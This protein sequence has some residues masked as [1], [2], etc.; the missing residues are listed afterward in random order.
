MKFRNFKIKFLILSSVFCLLSSLF[1]VAPAIQADETS[2]NSYNQSNLNQ[3]VPRNLNTWTQSIMIE[4]MSSL[5]CQ[6]TGVNPANPSQSC[7]GVDQKTGKIGFMENGGGAIGVMGH[8]IGMLYN[9]PVHTGDFT[10][11]LAQN[12]GIT[13]TAYAQSATGFNTLSPLIG[14][15]SAFRNIVYIVL[16]IIFVLIGLAIMFRVKIDPRTVMTIQNQI[17]KIIIAMVLVT[18]SYA[19]AGLM[20]DFMYLLMYFLFNIFAT[21]PATGTTTIDVTSLNPANLQGKSPFSIIGDIPS[22]AGNVSGSVKDV[23]NSLLGGGLLSFIGWLGGSTAYFIILIAIIWSLFRLWFTLISAFIYILIAIVLSPFWIAGSLIPG[24]KISFGAWIRHIVSYLAVFPLTIGLFLLGKSF[25]DAFGTTQGAGVFVPPLIGNA[26]VP[27]AI[28]SIIGFGTILLA[29]N[30]QHISTKL[31]G[32]PN[33]DVGPV[34][35]AIGIGIGAP[36][37]IVGSTS[38]LGSTLFGLSNVPGVR[39]L[40]II[41]SIKGSNTSGTSAPQH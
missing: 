4:V 39:H 25:M 15:W 21:I 32:P 14:I 9:M 13:K 33:I 23:I 18:F 27:N 41:S 1:F 7:L 3:D 16:T 11:Y 2:A 31:F 10:E 19:I 17:P 8:M 28:G 20:I 38:Q 26:S 24:T 6:L 35:K 34:G 36:S 5:S 29:P 37:G 12:F 30:V 40:P 22:I